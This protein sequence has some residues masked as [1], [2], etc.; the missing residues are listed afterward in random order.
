MVFWRLGPGWYFQYPESDQV[1]GYEREW[2]DLLQEIQSKYLQGGFR[3]NKIAI[4]P[5]NLDG[6]D[7]TRQYAKEGGVKRVAPELFAPSPGRAVELLQL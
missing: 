7:W 2:Y 6:E 3:S 1:P 5:R 4:D